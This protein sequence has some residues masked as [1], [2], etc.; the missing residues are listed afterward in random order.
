M[1]NGAL[2]RRVLRRLLVWFC[3]EHTRLPF[4]VE[5]SRAVDCAI[6]LLEFLRR[7]PK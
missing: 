4:D 3:D 1:I 5:R 7:G 2:R 6:A